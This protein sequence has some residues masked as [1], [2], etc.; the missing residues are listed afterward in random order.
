LILR[1]TYNNVILFQFQDAGLLT[2]TSRP[3]G[4]NVVMIGAGKFD[5]K[6]TQSMA[7]DRDKI[8]EL[9]FSQKQDYCAIEIRKFGMAMTLG[10]IPGQELT[11]KN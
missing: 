5:T 3:W 1:A 7:M 2:T 11:E 6:V 10:R 4:E 9:S 8:T